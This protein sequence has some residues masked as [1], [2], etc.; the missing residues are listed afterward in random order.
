MTPTPPTETR[1]APGG[2]Q[3]VAVAG[4]E[5]DPLFGFSRP[6]RVICVVLVA[7][8]TVIYAQT[9]G[10][11][12]VTLD[13]L[14]YVIDNPR[15]NTGLS[16]ENVGWAFTHA[17]SANWH[18]LTWVSHMLDCELFG[19]SAGGHHFHAA[20]LHAAAAVFLFLAF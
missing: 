9:F 12:F 4:A 19:L 20:L 16:A 7:A 11:D 1:P 8:V 2:A 3:S 17:H 18:P 5:R 14:E 13:D 10:H 6:D 15:V